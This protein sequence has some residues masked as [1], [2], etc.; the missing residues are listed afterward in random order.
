MQESDR[1]ESLVSGEAPFDAKSIG[2]SVRHDSSIMEEDIP[3]YQEE[4]QGMSKDDEF[5]IHDMLQRMVLTRS[6]IETYLGLPESELKKVLVGCFVR[7]K[8]PVQGSGETK[9]RP[10]IVEIVAVQPAETPYLP[11]GSTKKLN[12]HLVVE[13][14]KAGQGSRRAVQVDLISDQ[15][16]VQDTLKEEMKAWKETQDKV[17][18]EGM[19]NKCMAKMIDIEEA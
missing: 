8:L 5:K 11:K 3:L 1:P 2:E 7:L 6:K 13:R 19:M 17:R 15:M 12:W 10:V 9:T 4:P 14:V 16:P 18:Q